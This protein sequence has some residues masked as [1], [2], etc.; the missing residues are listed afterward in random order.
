M[1]P[2]DT[3]AGLSS[4]DGGTGGSENLIVV[5]TA[6]DLLERLESGTAGLMLLRLIYETGGIGALAFSPEAGA[7]DLR[8][9]LEQVSRLF[10][11]S[12]RVLSEAGTLFVWTDPFIEAHHRLLADRVFGA[13]HFQTQIILPENTGMILER[14]WPDYHVILVYTMSERSGIGAPFR[15]RTPDE[16]RA[17]YHASDAGGLYRLRDLTH[18]SPWPRLR[19]TFEGVTPPLNRGWRYTPEVLAQLYEEGRMVLRPDRA[20]AYLKSYLADEAQI[21]VGSI[22]EDLRNAEHNEEEMWPEEDAVMALVR[23]PLDTVARF[24]EMGSRP[25]DLV[26]APWDGAGSVA[27]AAS[28]LQRRWTIGVNVRGFS[29]R[30]I[31]RLSRYGYELKTHFRMIDVVDVEET[32]PAVER[33]YTDLL[34]GLAPE[35][36]RS[37]V[38][39]ERVPYEESLHVEFKEIR[40]SR[41]RDRIKEDADEYAVGFLNREGGRILWGIRDNGITVGVRLDGGER[42]DIRRLIDDQLSHVDPPVAPTQYSIRFHP[43]VLA[44]PADLDLCVVELRVNRGDPHEL[45][46]TGTGTYFMKT[47]SGNKQ[48]K[49]RAQKDEILRRL[50]FT[51]RN[52]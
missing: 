11:Q 15:L 40:G 51:Q 35:R 32:L 16:V 50:A 7:R 41:P 6:L 47:D 25:G 19:Y 27:I 39:G 44:R 9:H 1:H 5:A 36:S 48:L 43:I 31:A 8:E 2:S 10:Q 22:W 49:G 34:A 18:P 24:L 33:S 52:P 46:C 21:P 29:S 42:D 28:R 23:F 14:A 37:F 12:K 26:V 13:E 38:L 3:P 30:V 20:A 45:Y 4:D 17:E